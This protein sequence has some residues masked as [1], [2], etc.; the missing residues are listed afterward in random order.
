M[1]Q[2]GL[3]L[4]LLITTSLQAQ[5][6]KMSELS[7]N[8][9]LDSEII[10]EENGEDIWG[11]FLLYKADMVS[12]DFLKLEYIV[13][14]KNLNKVGSNTFEHDCY[15]SWLVDIMPTINSIYKNKNELLFAIGFDYDEMITHS[16]YVF[17][18]INLNDF[19]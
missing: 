11:Y 5:I 19:D 13:L 14:D 7:Q 12:K 1:K 4:L 6:Q 10:Y 3:L 8:K 17:R 18:K 15:D 16:P 9:F 2:I